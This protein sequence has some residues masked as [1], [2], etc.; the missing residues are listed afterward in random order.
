LFHFGLYGERGGSD[1]FGIHGHLAVSEDFEAKLF[2][3]ASEDV[4]AF[5]TQ[6]NVFWKKYHCHAVLAKWWQVSAELKAF[7]E[8]EFVRG[9]YED[10]CAVTGIVF[11]SAGAAVFHVF[12]HGECV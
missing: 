1:A 6:A 7:F 9:L 8:E 11:A 3:G 2:G 4:A 12:Q 5:F 10:A